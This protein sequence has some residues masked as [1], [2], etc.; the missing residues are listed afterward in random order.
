[1][2]V[3]RS[4]FESQIGLLNLPVCRHARFFKRRFQPFS[5]PDGG[6]SKLI[7]ND[8]LVKKSLDTALSL[9]RH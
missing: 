1:M 8:T 2:N 6:Q 3:T 4:G 7:R 5:L 9:S